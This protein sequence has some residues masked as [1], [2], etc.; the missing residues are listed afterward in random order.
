MASRSLAVQKLLK[1]YPNMFDDEEAD[2]NRRIEA[3]RAKNAA[4]VERHRE[5]EKMR[6]EEEKID[7]RV[8]AE[9]ES[10][11]QNAA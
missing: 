10:Q 8:K 1:L 11:K 4:R 2:L 6:L 5:I 3:I 9:N 7:R